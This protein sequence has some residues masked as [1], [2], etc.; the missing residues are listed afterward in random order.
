MNKRMRKK[1]QLEREVKFLRS[2]LAGL[3]GWVTVLEEA[4]KTQLKRIAELTDRLETFE[5]INE[6]NVVVANEKFVALEKECQELR[7][8]LNKIYLQKKPWWK[9]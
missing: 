1:K 7:K 8:E 6:D 2:Q 4:E 5:K 9:R 3:L